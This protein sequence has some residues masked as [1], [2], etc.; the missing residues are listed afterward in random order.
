MI[1]ADVVKMYKDVHTWVGI[2]S[3]LALFIAFYAG[4]ITMF[5]GPL[6]QWASPPSDLP[7]PVPLERSAELVEKTIAAHPEAAGGYTLHIETDAANPARMSWL[8]W[9]EGRSRGAPNETW[10]SALDA[11]G[12]LVVAQDGSTPVAQFI[13][14]LH[15]QV[16]L[17]LDHELAML[18][19]GAVCLLY[20]VALVSGVIVFLPGVAKDL[21]ALR[22][23]RNLKRMWLDVHN[24]LGVFSL[25]FHI[26]MALT[27]LVF[28]FH[29]QIY[30][31]QNEITYDGQIAQMFEAG[32]PVHHV[33]IDPARDFLELPDLLA[34]LDAQVPQF[35]IQQIQY[36]VR[37]GNEAEVM[38]RGIDDR[39]GHRGPDFGMAA[40]N[41]YTG[42]IM[43]RTYLPGQQPASSAVLTSFFALHFGNFGGVPVRW[44]YFF[45]GLAGAFLFYSGNLLWIES[46]RKKAR[47][48]NPDP[49]QPLKTKVLGAL[50]VG[51]SLGCIAGISLTLSAAKFLPGRVQDLELWH[52]L[53]YYGV[54]IAAIGWAFLR[55]TARSAVELQ[56]AAAVATL[57]IPLVSVL[58]V[59]VPGLGWTHP[60]QSWLVE[61]TAVAG[62]GLLFFTAHRTRRRIRQAPEDSI[63]WAGPARSSA[64]TENAQHVAAE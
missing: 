39:Y 47:K 22:I 34:R 8:V 59:L 2:L 45:L 55:G 62:A 57:S 44:G 28:A 15:Q 26:I 35:S 27:A 64:V 30:D 50:T 25:P 16:G 51:I 17:P 32:E 37:P 38:A 54:F 1:R 63:W 19:M 9:P 36:M 43:S 24:V 42:D 4:A 5:E 60:G 46:R 18:I 13:D 52:S 58:S 48:S 40:I 31:L 23:G 14:V 3:G 12:E 56:W 7:A 20:F 49:V 6:K 29:D 33:D 11:N 21:F 10:F 61:I 41:P 53:I